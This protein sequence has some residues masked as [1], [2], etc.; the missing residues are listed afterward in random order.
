MKRK[1]NEKSIDILQ[2][3]LSVFN[4]FLTKTILVYKFYSIG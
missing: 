1:E 4:L 2:Y 3:L